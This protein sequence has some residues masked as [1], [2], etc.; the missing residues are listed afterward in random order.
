MKSTWLLKTAPTW[1]EAYARSC[2]RWSR[3]TV[4]S[5]A[6]LCSGSCR[7][8]LGWALWVAKPPT[9]TCHPCCGRRGWPR[10]TRPWPWPCGALAVSWA[11]SC[12]GCWPTGSSC[13]PPPCPPWPTSCWA[14]SSSSWLCSLGP[15]RHGWRSPWCTGYWRASTFACCPWWSSTSCR[16]RSLRPP[17]A[18]RA[19]P[20]VWPWPCCILSLVSNK[21]HCSIGILVCGHHWW[22][23]EVIGPILYLV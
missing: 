16:S 4:S 6:T 19:Y 21:G 10:G 18:S 14:R 23:T 7:C 12:A 13:G 8:T 17:S 22:G 9:H 2:G 5:F 11:A 3:V 15:W 20:R 1:K